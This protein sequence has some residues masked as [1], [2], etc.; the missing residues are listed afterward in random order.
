MINLCIGYLHIGIS[1]LSKDF[2]C[3]NVQITWVE[4]A[5]LKVPWAISD[6]IKCVPQIKTILI[7]LKFN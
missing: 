5:N 6:F 7:Q 2:G 3:L 1:Y 4:F